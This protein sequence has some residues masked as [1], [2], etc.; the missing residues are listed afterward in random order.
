M[1][2]PLESAIC[3]PSTGLKKKKKKLLK[4]KKKK[5]QLAAE[6]C[7]GVGMENEVQKDY[8]VNQKKK[9]VTSEERK[10]RSEGKIVTR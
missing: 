5:V 6:T 4:K 1:E 7:K 9:P 8:L 10:S 2:S 3:T